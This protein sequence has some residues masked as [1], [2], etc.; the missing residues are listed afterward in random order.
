MWSPPTITILDTKTD[1]VV[2]SLPGEPGCHGANFGLKQGSG[3][4]AYV[5]SKFAIGRQG[6]A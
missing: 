3:Y 5:A 6:Q 4:Y 2:K 1:K